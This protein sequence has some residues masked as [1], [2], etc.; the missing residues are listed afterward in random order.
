MAGMTPTPQRRENVDFS[1][2]YYEA[3]DTIVASISSNLTKP[4]DLSGKI[5]GVQLGTIQEQ[6]AKQIAEKVAKYQ[7]KTIK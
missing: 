4:E 1:I 6:N 7:V 5:V 2:I 3:T